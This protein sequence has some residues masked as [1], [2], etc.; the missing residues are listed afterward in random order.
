MIIIVIPA[1]GGSGR[2]P[3]KNI[4]PLNGLP[5]M[6]YTI[7]EAR[8]SQR[9]DEIYVSTDN[10]EIAANAEKN[11]VKVI[12][13]PESL[14]GDVPIVDVYRHAVA[15]LDDANV[16]IVVGLQPD[17]P[18]RDISV[19]EALAIFDKEEVDCLYSEEAD[20]TKNGA[21]FIM[22][23]QFLD[24]DESRKDIYIVDDC[25]NVHYQEDLDAAAVRLRERQSAS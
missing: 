7:M 24:S 11:G 16:S 13:R 19:D 10:D 1:K 3:K 9:V 21:H 18:D 23:R 12:R 2:L 4:A 6:D 5:M 20:G 25:T 15:Q 17:H 22:S 14:G 8:R